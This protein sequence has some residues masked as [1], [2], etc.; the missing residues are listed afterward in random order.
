ML[1]LLARL[2]ASSTLPNSNKVGSR[3]GL[4]LGCFAIAEVYRGAFGELKLPIEDDSPSG[5]LIDVN[6]T[7]SLSKTP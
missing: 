4:T 6:S 2:A 1:S 3:I 7:L 5:I